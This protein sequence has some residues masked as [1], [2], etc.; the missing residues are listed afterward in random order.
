MT[1]VSILHGASPRGGEVA[2]QPDHFSD[3]NLD[4]V[5]TS[6]V[7]RREEYDL[8]PLFLSPVRDEATVRHRQAAVAE[9]ERLEVREVVDRFAE[10]MRVVRRRRDMARSLRHRYHRER[11]LLASTT[12]YCE[13]VTP[14]AEGLDRVRISSEAFRGL[15]GFLHHYISSSRFSSAREQGIMLEEELAELRFA[16][17]VR[18]DRVTVRS[19]EGGDDYGVEVEKTFAKFKQGEVKDY[20]VESSPSTCPVGSG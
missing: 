8:T 17:Q 14:L 12:S 6:L 9:L 13:A 18:G 15:R 19:Y 10:T 3:L 1:F 11:W 4:Q 16:V 20:R 7:N 5:V 2:E